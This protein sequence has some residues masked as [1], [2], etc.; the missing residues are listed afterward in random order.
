MKKQ[1]SYI[2]KNSDTTRI[3]NEQFITA[4]NAKT[5]DGYYISSLYESSIEKTEDTVIFKAYL[6]K[7]IDLKTKSGQKELKQILSSQKSPL[8]K[9]ITDTEKEYRRNYEETILNGGTPNKLYT[10]TPE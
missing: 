10:I 2:T 6:E 4:K 3:K 8:P 7:T 5:P 1:K 9:L